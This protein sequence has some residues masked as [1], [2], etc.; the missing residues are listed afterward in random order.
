M[1]FFNLF[2]KKE[3]REAPQSPLQQTYEQ[4][5][6]HQSYCDVVQKQNDFLK[7]IFQKYKYDA[8]SQSAVFA[9]IN[10]ISNTISQMPWDVKY[11]DDNEIDISYINNLTYNSNVTKFN[12]VKNMIKDVLIRGNGFAYIERDGNGKPKTLRYLRPDQVI[13]FY[14]DQT[15]KLLYQVPV[16]NKR[17]YIEPINMI[18]FVI[19]SKDGIQ[20]IGVLEF[21]H[22]SIDLGA[23]TDKATKE[24]FKNG[25]TVQGIIKSPNRN[26]QE[27]ERKKIRS[28]WMNTEGG[29]RMLEGG[30]EYQQ[31]QSSS[32]EAE[33]TANRSFNVIE[34]ARFF[35]INPILLGDLTHTQYGSIEQANLEFIT[36]T[37]AP[38]IIMMEEEL[39]RKLVMPSHKGKIYIDIDEEIVIRMDKNSLANYVGNLV[40]KGIMTV[41]E[42]REK[43]GLPWKDGADDLVTYYNNHNTNNEEDVDTNNTLY[44]NNNKENEE[45]Y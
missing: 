12:I 29:I 30:L 21:A 20:G 40:T 11:I 19:N 31:V 39:N 13:I 14:N 1:N 26:V 41:N 7:Q 45:E 16:L 42:A 17:R 32:K 24:Y 18:H 36:H 5:L 27:T 15:D 44:K 2:G 37:L 10:I 35:N 23:Y 25:M 22:N 6:E 38:Y 43:L 8:M 34:I 3:V 9:A 33:L 4:S 28:G